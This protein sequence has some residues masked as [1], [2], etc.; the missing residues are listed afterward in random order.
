MSVSVERIIGALLLCAVFGV[1]GYF[2][3]QYAPFTGSLASIA[4]P[5]SRVRNKTAIGYRGGLI[6]V[7]SGLFTSPKKPEA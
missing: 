5:F 7:V 6:G 3:G 2:V 1:V 4:E